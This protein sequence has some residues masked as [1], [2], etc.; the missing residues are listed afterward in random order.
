MP[1]FIDL[2]ISTEFFYRRDFISNLHQ[3]FVLNYTF[4]PIFCLKLY[5]EFKNEIL[6]DQQHSLNGFINKSYIMVNEVISSLCPVDK[7]CSLHL[8]FRALLLVKNI[9]LLPKTIFAPRVCLRRHCLSKGFCNLA[10]HKF[11]G[12]SEY[13]Q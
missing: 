9:S 3:H 13:T 5:S 4:S 10:S 2:V 7:R 1:P 8:P 11:Q 6:W 12:I